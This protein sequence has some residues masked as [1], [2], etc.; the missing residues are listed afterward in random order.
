[1]RRQTGVGSPELTLIVIGVLGVSLSGPL[2]AAATAV[3]ALAMSLWRTGLGSLASLPRCLS[4]HRAELA[5][6]SGRDLRLTIWSGVMLAGH[7]ACWTAS[8]KLTS[9]ASATA[10][11]CLQAAWVV[12]LSR[13]LGTPASARIWWGLLVA[14]AGVL[15]IS[16]VDLTTSPRALGGDGLAF[17]GAVFSALY[18]L[19]G[20]RVRQ[21]ASTS[22]YTMLCYGVS[23]LVLLA[24]ALGSGTSLAG[25][26]LRG[27]LL[28]LA[29]T[30]AS[31]LLGHSVFNH[32]LATISPRVVSM[33]LLL[34]VPGAA[35][36]AALLLGQAPP[37]AVY[38]GLALICAGL[39]V[40]AGGRQQ[41]TPALAVD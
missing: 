15:T 10:L 40:L 11:V 24:A 33:A 19:I 31:Q 26:P 3:P 39:A 18:T 7:F 6:L 16:G 20:A 5:G 36:L 37:I 29:V 8:L 2:M 4:R 14:L 27:W 17:A 9:V 13:L 22:T 1:M 21:V 35:L 41:S 12:V 30:V 34:E 25:F 38:A 32:L 28:I 23:A